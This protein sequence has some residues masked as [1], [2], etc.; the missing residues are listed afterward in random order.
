M[1]FVLLK[2]LF[3]FDDKN[4]NEGELKNNSD[5]VMIKPTHKHKQIGGDR[6]TVV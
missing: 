6:H 3:Y 2:I 4:P 1:A 5:K